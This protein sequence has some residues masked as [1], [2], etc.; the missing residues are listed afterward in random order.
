M[1]FRHHI[2][3]SPAII[4]I[5][6][7]VCGM[8]RTSA[9]GAPAG[10]QRAPASP[11]AVGAIAQLTGTCPDLTFVLSGVTVHA[12]AATKFE[13]GGCADLKDG[14]QTGAMGPKRADGSIDAAR[15]RIGVSSPAP[16]ATAP[17]RAQGPVSALTGRC[18][19]L[20]FTLSGTSVTTSATTRYQGGACE[21][22]KE[23]VRAGATGTKDPSGA[24]AA[25]NVRIFPPPP[26]VVNGTISGSSGS[27]PA[28]TFTLA[29]TT[30]H[31]TDK[32][33]FAGG[34]CADV[35]DG[36]RASA[37]GPKAADG[38]LTAEAVRLPPAK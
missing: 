2:L 5:L 36:V 18:P 26:P 29:N 28:L 17:P 11:R 6:A 21:D 33:Q 23:G 31:T 13:N 3:G 35:K 14:V 34:T 10:G 12:S 16:A 32:T 7:L 25:A 38:S 9:Q 19:A 24:I 4:A 37:R 20:T 30:I 27:C 15:V 8:P 1:P 22:L